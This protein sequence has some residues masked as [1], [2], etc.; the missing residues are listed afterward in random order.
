LLYSTFL[1]GSGGDEG[2]AIA[3]ASG[4]AYVTGI[5]NSFNFPEAGNTPAGGAD[6]FVS[7]FT[8]DG[9]ALIFSLYLG[10]GAFDA[11][12]GI[13][14]HISQGIVQAV[15]VTGRTTSHD[16]PIFGLG[17]R[18]DTGAADAF[19]VKLAADGTQLFY[20]TYLGGSSADDGHCIA[21]DA[22]GRA[23][24]GGVT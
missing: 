6:V 24:V 1:G 23:Y 20:S 15:L 7:R 21:T 19:V 16:F 4:E 9:S 3:Q 18:G 14:L 13:A 10:G 5:T 22:A 12:Q 11:G 8:E 17:A 2:L